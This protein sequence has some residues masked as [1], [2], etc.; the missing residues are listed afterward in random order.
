MNGAPKVKWEC[1]ID[2]PRGPAIAGSIAVRDY[3]FQ[4]AAHIGPPRRRPRDVMKRHEA[5]RLIRDELHRAI[6]S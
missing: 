5:M 2:G 6:A 1:W 4:L 3:L